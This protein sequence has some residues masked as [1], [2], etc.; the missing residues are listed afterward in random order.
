MVEKLDNKK[1]DMKV[2]AM[3]LCWV[4]KKGAGL[5]MRTG[6]YSAALKDAQKVA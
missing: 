4:G 6:R 2:H 1:E 3:V 5:E